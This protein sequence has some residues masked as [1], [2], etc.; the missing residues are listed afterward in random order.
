MVV[1]VDEVNEGKKLQKKKHNNKKNDSPQ[2][3]NKNKNSQLRVAA[4][5]RNPEYDKS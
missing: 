1:L 2:N 5:L 4:T 3:K